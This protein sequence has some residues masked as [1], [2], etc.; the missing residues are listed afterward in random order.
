M[1]LWWSDTPIFTYKRAEKA[2]RE[3]MTDV[4][5]KKEWLYDKTLWR[6]HRLEQKER[7]REMKHEWALQ[8]VKQGAATLVP[9]VTYKCDKCERIENIYLDATRALVEILSSNDCIG[10]SPIWSKDEKGEL[11]LRDRV[12]WL[13]HGLGDKERLDM[14]TE[15]LAEISNRLDKLEAPLEVDYGKR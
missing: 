11:T 7:A 4:R 3:T 1:K 12:A 6:Y 8:E 2:F 14:I 10:Q 9:I 15:A 13:R 5:L